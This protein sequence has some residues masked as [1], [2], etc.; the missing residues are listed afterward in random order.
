MTSQDSGWVS[1]QAAFQ[2]RCSHPDMHVLSGACSLEKSQ[3][4]AEARPLGG[5]GEDRFPPYAMATQ[6]AFPREHNASHIFLFVRL[7]R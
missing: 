1:I 2:I 7:A 3:W 4:E 5:L 6:G